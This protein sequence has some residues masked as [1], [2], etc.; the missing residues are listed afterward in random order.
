MGRDNSVSYS[1]TASNSKARSG[2]Q[3]KIK[4]KPSKKQS[5]RDSTAEKD[6]HKLGTALEDQADVEAFD[7]PEK[8]TKIKTQE[9]SKILHGKES[10]EKL[11]LKSW[12]SHLEKNQSIVSDVLM[13]QFMTKLECTVCKN[14]SFNFEPFYVIELP[15]PQGNEVLTLSDLLGKLAK[16]DLVEGFEW[17][18]PTC[19][20]KRQV[21]KSTKIYKL[22]PVLV[23]CYKRF[24]MFQGKSRKNNSLVNLK[25]NGEDLSR[26]EHGGIGSG[27]KIY[28]PYM[29][30]VDFDYRASPRRNRRRPL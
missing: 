29:F 24:Y 25:I 28:I 1:E 15:L 22:P 2:S 4:K 20:Q 13:G 12:R 19:L 14:S 27:P 17:D 3:K 8:K 10:L 21:R 18:C 16:E 30:I 7:D 9:S 6:K 26:F 5:A 11:S 23:I